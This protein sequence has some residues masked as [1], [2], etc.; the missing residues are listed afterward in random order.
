MVLLSCVRVCGVLT[1]ELG[2]VSRVSDQCDGVR[3]HELSLISTR[4]IDIGGDRSLLI[5][6]IKK[7]IDIYEE[8]DS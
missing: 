8:I 4:F 5:A 1:W 6:K 2:E 3:G 7:I